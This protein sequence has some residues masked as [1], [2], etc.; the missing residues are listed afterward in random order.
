MV[1]VHQAVG[2]Q[3]RQHLREFVLV[4]L[5]KPCGGLLE[6]LAPTTST[7]CRCVWACQAYEKEILATLM[8]PLLLGA[9]VAHSSPTTPTWFC[10]GDV[11]PFLEAFTVVIPLGFVD[12]CG[13]Y[14]KRGGWS[15][16][17]SITPRSVRRPGC[18]PI[19]EDLIF[20]PLPVDFCEKYTW[21][22][23]SP[24]VYTWSSWFDRQ[25]LVCRV[26][27]IVEPHWEICSLLM[28]TAPMQDGRHLQHLDKVWWSPSGS[29][30]ST[31]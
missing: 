12:T 19:S 24:V 2:L 23:V 22:M 25:R 15:Y 1:L 7:W 20:T 10:L 17:P 11:D 3:A 4:W 31:R 29:P 30:M 26:H 14:G 28:V 21:S 16:P 5:A 6:L 27:E 18:Q 9:V 13:N 8:V